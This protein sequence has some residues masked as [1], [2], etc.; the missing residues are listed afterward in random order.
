M[1]IRRQMVQK[2]GGGA[3]S[4]VAG[5]I[6]PPPVGIGLIDLPKIFWH[7]YRTGKKVVDEKFNFCN[8]KDLC[9]H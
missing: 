9:K 4:N 6:C 7:P 2:Y 3:G 8:I 1:H 5:I